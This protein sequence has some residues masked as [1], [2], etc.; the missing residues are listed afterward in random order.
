MVQKP[1]IPRQTTSHLNQRVPGVRY[2]CQRSAGTR[3]DLKLLRFVRLDDTLHRYEILGHGY[4][5]QFREF[6]D[7]DVV[8]VFDNQD[9]LPKS[10]GLSPC[11]VRVR[12]WKIMEDLCSAML[13][14]PY[15]D[16]KV[17]E[18]AQLTI[19]GTQDL[20][21]RPR[22]ESPAETS[23]A[24]PWK[25]DFFRLL[26]LGKLKNTLF[27]WDFLVGFVGEFCR[28][29]FFWSLNFQSPAQECWES[30]SLPAGDVQ[31]G[32]WDPAARAST[33]ARPSR[34]SPGSTA[35]GL[36]CWSCREVGICQRWEAKW[37]LCLT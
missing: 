9:V 27:C 5:L 28:C 20:P 13:R 2:I 17:E 26:G 22:A 14:Y 8:T 35:M 19:L 32:P 33:T 3:L 24:V 25:H 37:L 7:Q 16:S 6:R 1:L 18:L 36:R 34:P 15:H 12:Q 10:P 21:W 11:R 29:K 30:R 4:S 23:G 31:R